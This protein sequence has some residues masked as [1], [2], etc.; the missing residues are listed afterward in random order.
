MVA[1]MAVWTVACWA[2]QMVVLSAKLTVDYSA[3]VKVD[4][5]VDAMVDSWA[6]GLE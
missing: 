6:A 4:P 3:A 2:D 5:M 1:S